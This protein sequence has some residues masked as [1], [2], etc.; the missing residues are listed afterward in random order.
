ML[1]QFCSI[2]ETS[3]FQKQ[4]V[5]QCPISA[6]CQNH[7]EQKEKVFSSLLDFSH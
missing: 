7:G 3:T 4:E 1:I 2:C 5:S 6:W